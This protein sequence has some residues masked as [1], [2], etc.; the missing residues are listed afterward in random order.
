MVHDKDKYIDEIEEWSRQ[1]LKENQDLADKVEALE[2][3]VERL[4]NELQ[5][6]RNKT[7]P[8]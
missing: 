6:E 3:E 4:T 8:L 7:N 2:L 5:S 1:I